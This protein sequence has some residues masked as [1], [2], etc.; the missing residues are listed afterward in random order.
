M[1]AIYDGAAEFENKA[2]RTRQACPA[3]WLPGR[4]MNERATSA[5]A[6]LEKPE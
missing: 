2:G 4:R 6:R 5:V 3:L 1:A